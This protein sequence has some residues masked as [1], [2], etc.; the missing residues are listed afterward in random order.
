MM[1]KTLRTVVVPLIVVLCCQTLC[2]HETALHSKK[3]STNYTGNMARNALEICNN[4]WGTSWLSPTYQSE[5]YDGSWDEDNSA[6]RYIN[7]GYNPIT[8][9]TGGIFIGGQPTIDY[10]IPLWEDM[11][12]AF[13]SGHLTGGDG[14]YH[15]LGRC[16]HLLQDMTTYVH[17]HPQDITGLPYDPINK[18]HQDFEA[19]ELSSFQNYDFPNTYPPLLP[20]DSLTDVSQSTEKLDSF[21]ANRLRSKTFA[22]NHIASFIEQVARITYFRS[23]FWGEVQFVSETGNGEA[24]PE[25][26]TG[27]SFGTT[28]IFPQP[29]V[30]RIM[31]G[32]ANVRYVNT[33]DDD[34]FEITDADNEGFTWKS[35]VDDEWFP[36]AESSI[37]ER[38]PDGHVIVGGSDPTDASV[39]TT[40]RFHFTRAYDV[41]PVKYPDNTSFADSSLGYYISYYSM[42]V[43]LRYN[44]A[45]MGVG[46]GLQRTLSFQSQNPSSGVWIE[47]YN[48]ENLQTIVYNT[49]NSGSYKY[50]TVMT[51][52]APAAVSGNTFSKWQKNGSDYS[53]NRQI[54]VTARANDIYKAVYVTGPTHQKYVYGGCVTSRSLGAS[55]PWPAID[56]ST[57]FDYL[58]DPDHLCMRIELLDVYENG[59]RSPLIHVECKLYKPNGEYY[60]YVYW[61]VDDPGAGYYWPSYIC[62]VEEGWFNNHNYRFEDWPGRW[63]YKI[64]IDEGEGEDTEL[65]EEKYFDVLA[66]TVVT[67]TFS[68]DGGT[69]T[70]PVSVTVSC[71]TPGATI[72]YTTDG[73]NPAETSL[74]YTSPVSIS[75]TKTLK[76]KAWKHHWFP[77]GV[78]SA[79][80]TI[81]G[82]VA[83]PTFSPDGGTYTSPVDVTIS[84]GASGATIHYTTNGVDPAESDPVYTSPINISTTTTLKAKAWKSGWNPSGVRS[85]TYTITGTVSTPT[86]SP[87]GGTYT[88]PVDVTISCSTSGAT[89][90]YTTNGGTPTE[91]DPVYTGPINI[92]TTTT[93]KAK[94]WKSG[95]NPS[96]VETET[97]SILVACVITASAGPSGSINPNGIFD[98]NFGDDVQFSALPDS[99]YAVDQWYL[100]GNSVQQGNTSYT[101]YDVQADHN[102]LVT[103]IEIPPM[104]L[105][106]DGIVNFIDFAIL[107][108]SW[109]LS[110]ESDN[111]VNNGSFDTDILG[112]T[113]YDDP[114]LS[115]GTV[116][117]VYDDA[118]GLPVGS[119]FIKA[120]TGTS[121]ADYH[122]FYQVIPVTIGRQ[123]K[124]SGN[125]KGSIAGTVP[126]PP[127][128]RNWAELWV[129]FVS[130]GPDTTPANWGSIMY[131][132]AYGNGNLNTST[133][134]WDWESILASPNNDPNSPP[135]GI[136]TATDTYMVIFF[137]VGGRTNSGSPWIN[138]DNVKVM[139]VGA[140]ITYWPIG[141]LNGDCFVDFNDIDTFTLN[142]LAYTP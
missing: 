106:N 41:D 101:L 11:V 43:G 135:E 74:T 81:T 88:S 5:I 2:G 120:E 102:V 67:P 69:Y 100:D 35:T 96:A 25:N 9:T 10:S 39:R 6:F 12:D 21:S 54:E 56:P 83:T 63:T 103:F 79:N 18:E 115:K 124:I 136:F 107:A 51:L 108:S 123:Y 4:A 72:H 24:A 27:T 122:F 38:M 61:D 8:G 89:I 47:V 53:T 111:L 55:N 139:E 52:T 29:N 141:D 110:C 31:F 66:E 13:N 132:K 28:W 104:D 45:L 57:Q 75:S 131:K 73:S 127:T 97:Y 77:S 70:S 40:G 20:T 65:I 137:H 113:L 49:P 36:C 92:S 134:V 1:S 33:W 58:N 121:G 125:W 133:G 60:G 46:S 71:T 76:A 94:A 34:Y 44:A 117:V 118:N 17:I 114:L 80:Y 23:T 93:L 62:Y 59:D 64:Y 16:C 109:Q 138:A 7:H 32:A 85:E 90:H 37:P 140:P 98:V 112:W 126:D 14:A 105:N 91:S 84:C 82:T 22:D 129:G 68:P 128:A 3:G 50:G 130:T 86:F 87:G 48:H 99:N 26:T 19:L 15:Y 116:S 30:L 142:W 119:A 78:K 95:W 42:L